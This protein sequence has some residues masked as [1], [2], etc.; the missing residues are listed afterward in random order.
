MNFKVIFKTLLSGFRENMGEG[1]KKMEIFDTLI[2][3]NKTK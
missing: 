1:R 3:L 2:S